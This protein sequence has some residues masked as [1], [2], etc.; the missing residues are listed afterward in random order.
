[1]AQTF[2]QK[3]KKKQDQLRSS[4]PKTQMVGDMILFYLPIN[5]CIYIYIPTLK[6]IPVFLCCFM[7]FKKSGFNG[8]VSAGTY[9]VSTS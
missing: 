8:A 6:I 5:V 2:K 9:F 3:T 4:F 7:K 1:M